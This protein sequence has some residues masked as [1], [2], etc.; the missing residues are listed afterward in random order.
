MRVTLIYDNEVLRQGL[1][2]GWGF[3]ALIEAGSAPPVLFDTGADGPTLLNNMAE[4]GIK[5]GDIG[6]IVLSHAHMDH[7][8]GLSA[9]LAENRQA[10]IFVPA[11]VRVVASDRKVIRV[12]GPRDIVGGIHTTGELMSIE[13]SLALETAAG[14]V[15]VTGC[16][17]PGV[18]EI[19]GAASKWGKL[20]GIIGGLHGFHDFDLLK[21][22]SLICPCHCTQY[23][24]EILRRFPE[25]SVTCGAGIVLEMDEP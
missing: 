16:S 4:L 18:G 22:L 8:G 25:Q 3:S 14:I 15:V 9:V 2:P 23:K 5:P 17:H 10:E 20:N 24:A 11:S 19:L 21:G 1:V 12:A 7:T 6:A 13:Q